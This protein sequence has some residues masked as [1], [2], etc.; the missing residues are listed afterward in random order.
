M[1]RFDFLQGRAHAAQAITGIFGEA[2]ELT[3]AS[4]IAEV[5]ANMRSSLPKYPKDYADGMLDVIERVQ[6][7]LDKSE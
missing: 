5:I 6:A 1:S 4:G 2:S 7:G 3:R